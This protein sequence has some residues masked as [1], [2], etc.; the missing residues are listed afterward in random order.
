MK[1][2]GLFNEVQEVKTLLSIPNKNQNLEKGFRF[3]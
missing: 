2:A 1:D 3:V